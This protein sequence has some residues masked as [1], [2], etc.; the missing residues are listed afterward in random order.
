MK[1]VAQIDYTAWQIKSQAPFNKLTLELWEWPAGRVL[2]LSSKIDANDGATA[3]AS[4]QQFVKSKGLSLSSVQGLKTS[5][6]LKAGPTPP[7]H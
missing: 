5:I 2:E 3:Y 1:R 7:P 4:L 6:V